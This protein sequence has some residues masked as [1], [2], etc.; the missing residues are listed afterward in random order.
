MSEEKVSMDAYGVQM[1]TCGITEEEHQRLLDL[2]GCMG[3]DTGH[4][5]W[6][7][8]WVYYLFISQKARDEALPIIQKSEYSWGAFIMKEPVRFTFEDGGDEDAG[9]DM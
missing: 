4:P 9:E 2:P 8:V 1:L 6:C 5:S 7:S 3:Y